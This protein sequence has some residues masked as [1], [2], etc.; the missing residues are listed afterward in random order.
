MAE[1]LVPNVTS[2][3]AEDA[4]RIRHAVDEVQR[5]AATVNSAAKAVG[6]SM[7]A[8][9]ASRVAAAA[10]LEATKETAT[11]IVA[12]KE[13][14]TSDQAVIAAKSDHIQQAQDH[15]DGVRANLDRTLTAATASANEAEAA[16]SKAQTGAT[17]IDEILGSVRSARVQVEADT[18][19]IDKAKTDGDAAVRALNGMAVRAREAEE[20][21]AEYEKR[22]SELEAQCKVQL[23][24]I[25]DLLPGATSAGLAHAF[26]ERR[27]TFLMPAQRWQRWFIGSLIVLAIL[28]LSELIPVFAGWTSDSYL[29]LGRAWLLRL[30]F[31]VSLIWLALHAAREAALA[32]RLEED[33]GYKSA[34]SASFQGF[35][36]Q[37]AKI[38]EAQ[39]DSPLSKLCADTLA[40]LASPPGRIYDKHALTTTPTDKIQEMIEK[41]LAKKPPEAPRG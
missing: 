21:V 2:I 11:A 12:I 31:A 20:K 25:T 4:D 22:L 17:N 27:Q 5:L 9:E 39:P 6:E 13:R 19:S 35:N 8:A 26:D 24:A 23:Q 34:I 16:R 29:D 32:K 33:Y 3:V 37:M 30:P 14:A 40:T 7:T 18:S 36:E 15:A 41:V 10:A 38:G 1:E 28:A